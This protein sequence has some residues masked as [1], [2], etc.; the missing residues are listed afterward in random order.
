MP[1]T[2]LVLPGYAGSGPEHWQTLWER[3]HGYVRVEQDDWERP[4]LAAWKRR[5][6]EAIEQAATP[7]VLVAHSLGCALV[8][9][10]AGDAVAGRIAGALL[11]A[12]PDV[13]EIRHLMPE[14]EDFAPV[15]LA[16]L[17]FPS[18]VVASTDDPYAEPER[19]RAFAAAWGARLV[20]LQAAGH[21]NAESDL[22]EWPEGHRLLEELLGV[23]KG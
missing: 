14:I 7:V 17:P 1:A 4:E 21:I 11:V 12:P 5:L 2:V 15:P 19:A 13:D 18:L 22:G 10:V 3:R 6:H 23:T 9:H 8:A 20:E 16:P